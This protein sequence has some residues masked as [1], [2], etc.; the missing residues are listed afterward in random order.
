MNGYKHEELKESL[1]K[2]RMND[3]PTAIIARTTKGKG[4]SF[5]EN[6]VEWHYKSPNDT[7]LIK[8]LGEVIEK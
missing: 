6:S 5:M 4:V 3:T 1:R 8:A 2:A 7:E